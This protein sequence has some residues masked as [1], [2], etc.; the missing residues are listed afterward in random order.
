[1]KLRALALIALITG[2]LFVA[3]SPA[4]AQR[5]IPGIKQTVA[6]KQLKNYVQFLGSRKNV[7]ASSTQKMTFRTNLNTRKRNA[8]Q[9]VNSLFQQ[10]LNRI[11]KQDDNQERRQVKQIRLAQKR[12]VQALKQDLADRIADIQEDQAQAVQ[13]VYNNYAPRIN[14]RADRRDALRRQ[15]NRTTNP[16][17][18]AALIRQINRLQTQINALVS[19]RTIAVNNVNAK[20]SARISKATNLY[21]ARIASVRASAQRQIQQAR[22]AWRQ[23]FRTQV[24]AARSRRDGQKEI[25]A[26][27][28]SRGVGFIEM[29]PPV[30][31]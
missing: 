7:P 24:A 23:T 20:Y 27:V 28:A 16:A 14:A 15:L 6:F 26:A 30:A 9:K 29:M 22:N 12:Q 25:V 1:M 4:S 10:K 11:S 8:N 31:E 3:A 18:R 2:L 17:K 5:P 13:R 19:D 21:N